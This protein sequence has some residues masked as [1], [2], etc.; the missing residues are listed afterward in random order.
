[1]AWN[2]TAPKNTDEETDRKQLAPG[3]GSSSQEGWD[4]ANEKASSK[5]P[6]WSK[7][8]ATRTGNQSNKQGG[9]KGNDIGVC[10]VNFGEFKV[11]L[12]GIM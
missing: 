11:R 1:M 7:S 12:N 5:R 6:S 4:G 10:H 2:E 9:T 3:I 8:V